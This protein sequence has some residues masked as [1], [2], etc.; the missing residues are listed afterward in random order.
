MVLQMEQKLHQTAQLSVFMHSH[1]LL[2]LSICFQMCLHVGH[3]DQ[4]THIHVLKQSFA[5]VGS[6]VE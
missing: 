6:C 3:A 2:Q 1:C 5:S 4:Q